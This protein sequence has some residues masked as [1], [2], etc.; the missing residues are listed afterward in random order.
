MTVVKPFKAYRPKPQF[1]AQVAAKPY[2]VINTSEAQQLAEGLPYSFLHISRAEIDLPANIDPYSPLV[3]EKAKN[4]FNEFIKNEVFVA[5]EQPCLYIYALEM[6]GKRQTGIMGLNSISDYLNNHIKKHEL[7][8]PEKEND[9]IAHIKHTSLNA[10]P[11]LMTYPQH[12]DIDAIVN[13]ITINQLP[14]YDF[15]STDNIR[16]IFW[17]INNAQTIQNIVQLFAQI[18]EIY[19]ADGHHRA[20][21]TTKTAQQ[22]ITEQN[23][24]DTTAPYCYMLSVLFPDNQLQIMDYNRVIKDLNG[25]S[26]EDFLNQL[27]QHC[28]LTCTQKQPKQPKQPNAFAMYL[29]GLWYSLNLTSYQPSENEI[30]NLG[31]TLISKYIIEPILG[32]ANQRTDKRIDF[33]GGIRGTSE[34]EKRVNSGEMQV[35]FWLCPPTMKQLLKI[36]DANQIMP[37]K[38]TWFEPKL[39][40]GLAVYKF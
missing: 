19:I 38:S 12:Q 4:N 28:T 1:V 29:D 15:I 36:A 34:L 11:I 13:N 27:Q 31:V 5:E 32:I 39:R 30:N 17:V 20:A 22:L 35:A 9:R 8:R 40:S 26:K 37:P 10:E 6:N 18:P 14:E 25:L 7:T 21:A 23:N 3:Y 2:D 33:V 16:H 24:P